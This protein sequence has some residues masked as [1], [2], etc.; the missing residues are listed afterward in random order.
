M[1]ERLEADVCVVGAGAGGAVAAAEL[2][3][4]G[5]RVVVLDQGPRHDPDDFTARPPEMLARLYRDGGQTATLGTPPIVL[6][7]GSGLGGTTL[8]NSG[9]CFR[10]PPH[11]LDRWNREFGLELDEQTLRPCFERVESALSVAEVSPELAGANA[12]IARRGA[13]RL[14]WSHGYLRRNARGCVGSG[15]CVFGCPTSAKQH[16]GITYIPRAEAAGA[17]IV[18]GAEVRELRVE[19]GRAR[20]VGARLADGRRLEV[21]AP[22]VVVACGTIHTPLLLERSGIDD[23]S[24]QRG[25]NLALH[26]ATAAFALMEDVVDMARGVPQ[27][28]YV[29]EFAAQGIM[30]EGVAG[31]PAYAAMSLPLTGDAHAR[32]M[33]DYRRLAQFGLMVSDSSRGRVHAV[34]GRPV[35]RYDLCADDLAK[36]RAGL[37]RLREL[38]HAA[39]AREVYLPLPAGVSPERARARDLTLM[40]FHPLGTARADARSSHGVTD[41]DLGVHGVAGLHVADGSVVPSALGVNPQL[42]IMALATRLA[43][44]LLGARVPRAAA[45][46]GS[47]LQPATH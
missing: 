33:A 22:T 16:T 17:R 29:D 42:T 40:A 36:F 43:F 47:K 13:E 11:V 25:R 3:E 39:G 35:I 34:A 32:A 38:F 30:F 20:G 8:V 14:G 2:A 10:T 28:F 1:S 18:T 26:P 6:P 23:R 31:P 21:R 19:G 37:A 45:P 7:L 46:S 4:G 9:T 41:G 12:A 27:S 44:R 5:A 15:V 24:G